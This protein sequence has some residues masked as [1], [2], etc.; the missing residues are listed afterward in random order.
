L[1][2]P[3]ISSRSSGCSTSDSNSTVAE[4]LAALNA[5]DFA[6][7]DRIRAEL[8][9]RGIQLMDYKDETGARQTRWEMK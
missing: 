9:A 7:A 3:P 1:A 4:R 5:R 2:V 6:G 8:L